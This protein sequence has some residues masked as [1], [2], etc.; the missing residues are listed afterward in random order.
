MEVD[1]AIPTG[2]FTQAGGLASGQA[3]DLCVQLTLPPGQHRL[4]AIVDAALSVPEVREN[5][6]RYEQ[7]VVAR[8]ISDSDDPS[9]HP[10]EGTTQTGQSVPVIQPTPSAPTGPTTRPTAAPSPTPSKGR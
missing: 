7:S 10:T 2:G 3:G 4:A 1:G 6:N 8:I 9:A 5:N